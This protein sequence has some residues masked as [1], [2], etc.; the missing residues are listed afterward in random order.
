MING[1]VN[2]RDAA[3]PSSGA[4]GI[5]VDK[6]FWDFWRFADYV[7]KK[8][9]TPQGLR[10]C[11]GRIERDRNWEPGNIRWYTRKELANHRIDNCY[12]TYRRKTQ[13]LTDWCDE[14]NLNYDR[15]HS[16][17]YQYGWTFL[18]AIDKKPRVSKKRKELA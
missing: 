11:L 10:N 18:E 9:G 12:Y 8:L 7:T 4:H 13:S 1:C 15:V 5:K 6:A 3:W 17:I 2:P 16:R 14:L